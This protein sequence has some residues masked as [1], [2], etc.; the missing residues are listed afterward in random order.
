M[1]YKTFLYVQ[2]LVFIKV[3]IEEVMLYLLLPPNGF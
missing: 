3:V 1:Y 2:I